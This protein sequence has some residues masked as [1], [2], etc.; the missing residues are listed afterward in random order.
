ME[1]VFSVLE[2]KN[3]NLRIMEREDLSIVKEWD[4]SIGIRANMSLLSKKLEQIW[5]G[6][7]TS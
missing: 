6:N 1:L 5:N 7:T 3:V 4:N 2:G